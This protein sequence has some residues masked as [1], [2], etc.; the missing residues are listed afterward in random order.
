MYYRHLFSDLIKKK[1]EYAIDNDQVTD[2]LRRAEEEFQELGDDASIEPML[3]VFPARWNIMYVT[4]FIRMMKYKMRSSSI[5][6]NKHYA[7]I[8]KLSIIV[9]NEAV[10][11]YDVRVA[12]MFFKDMLPTSIKY[13]KF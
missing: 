3:S 6:I 12:Q 4:T 9:Y 1:L 5:L 11:R 13:Q 7:N 8:E 10:L 2:A